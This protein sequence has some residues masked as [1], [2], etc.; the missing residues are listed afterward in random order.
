MEDYNEKFFYF[1]LND[2]VWDLYFQY[3]QTT[4]YICTCYIP[5]CFYEKLDLGV[6]IKLLLFTFFVIYENKSFAYF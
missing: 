6:A 3:L 1:K 4:M 2:L 5:V